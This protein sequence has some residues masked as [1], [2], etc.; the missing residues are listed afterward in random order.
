MEM[1]FSQLLSTY[2]GRTVEVFLANEFYTGVLMAV[3]VGYFTIQ[4]SVTSY[5][6]PATQVTIVNRQAEFVRILP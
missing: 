2:I 1:N 5:Y 4:V 6:S 3:E